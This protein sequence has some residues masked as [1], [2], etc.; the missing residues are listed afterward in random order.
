MRDPPF[1]AVGDASAVLARLTYPVWCPGQSVVGL[2]LS[3]DLLDLNICRSLLLGRATREREI[4]PKDL[5]G[6]QIGTRICSIC[7][8]RR[9]ECVKHGELPP[10]ATPQDRIL[11]LGE[12]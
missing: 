1:Q 2:V 6:A 9:A 11:S 10:V 8:S 4:R 7:V 3:Q 5:Q 12:G